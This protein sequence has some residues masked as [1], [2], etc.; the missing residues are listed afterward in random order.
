MPII[1][2][3]KVMPSSGQQKITL[4]KAGKLKCYLKSPPEQGKANQELVKLLSKMLKITQD[5]VTII[6]GQSSRNKT[7]KLDL[8]V[9]FEALLGLLEPSLLQ[10]YKKL[11]TGVCEGDKKGQGTLF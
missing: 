6:A 2:D 3:L 8:A 5:K 10:A 9:T 11:Q 7:V 1:I 4:D